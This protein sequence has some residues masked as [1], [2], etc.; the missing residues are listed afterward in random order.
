MAEGKRKEGEK[1]KTTIC[2]S[3]DV[4]NLNILDVIIYFI[5]RHHRKWIR[6]VTRR[7]SR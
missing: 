6:Q 2:V 3:L 7:H 1:E 4:R 5:E